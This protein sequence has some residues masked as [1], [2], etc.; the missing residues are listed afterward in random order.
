MFPNNKQQ[1]QE[2][3]LCKTWGK[4]LKL[5][6][7][8]YLLAAP[9]LY[10]VGAETTIVILGKR[11]SRNDQISDRKDS[12]NFIFLPPL[13]SAIIPFYSKQQHFL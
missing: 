2:L 10:W 8:S 6:H 11:D 4:L 3:R 1:F 13:Q 7:K 12:D 5:K 9:R